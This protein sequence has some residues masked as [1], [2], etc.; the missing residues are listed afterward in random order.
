[1]E[2][3]KA[4]AEVDMGIEMEAE[5]DKA[6]VETAEQ[7][8]SEA[9]LTLQEKYPRDEPLT[10][11]DARDLQSLFQAAYEWLAHNYEMV[12]RLNVFPV[13]D[14]DTGTN[15]L[16]TIKSA[17]TNIANRAH[18]TV[19]AV[20]EAAAEGAHHGSRGNSGVILGQILQ[21][22]SQGLREKATLNTYDLAQA[23]REATDSAYAAVPAPVE[24][25]ILTVSREISLAAEIAAQKTRDLREFLG[26]IVEAADEAVRHTPELLP[27]LKQAGVVDSGGKGLFFVFEGMHRALTG[28]PVKVDGDP[29][30]DQLVEESERS[31]ERKG[32]RALPPIQWGFDVQFLIEQPNKPVAMIAEEIAAMGDCPLVE[33]DERLVKVHVHLFDPG[34]AISY[35]VATGF[36][37]DIIVENMDDMAAAMQHRIEME[38][39]AD[40]AHAVNGFDRPTVLPT[41]P[42]ANGAATTDLPLN[43]ET[44]GVIAVT[45]GPGFAELFLHLGAHGVIEGGQSMNPSVADIVEAVHKLPMHQVIILP[46]NS[47]ILMAAQQAVKSVSKGERAHHLTVVATRTVPQGIAALTAYDPANT[48]ADDLAAQMTAH[49]ADVHTGEV[50][51]AVRSATVDGVEVMQGDIIGLH[52]GK[53]V[54]CGVGLAD[55][56]L[57]LLHKMSASEGALITLYYGDFVAEAAAQDFAE[58]VRREYP[59]QDIEFAYGGQPH[60]HYI[61]SV[62]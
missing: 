35:G 17:W 24:G 43:E 3:V 59:E 33:G 39:G 14:G 34:I 62:E 58:T 1:M 29:E 53:L 49:I 46:N 5:I 7:E 20:A 2:T 6:R 44:I 50:T 60:Y 12:N 21:G 15:M 41:S 51:Q 56:A 37:T 9:P 57:D 55:V 30:L 52:D 54:S 42:S 11:L 26:H 19:S 38:K 23:L 16:L 61:L 31:R 36:L 10:A 18:D 27:V 45:P 25:T 4:K 28:Q 47:N 22:F 13:P 40:A 8:A 32:H 48:K